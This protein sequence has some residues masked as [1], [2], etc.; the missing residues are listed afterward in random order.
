MDFQTVGRLLKAGATPDGAQVVRAKRAI[1]EELGSGSQTLGSLEKRVRESEGATLNF[2]ELQLADMSDEDLAKLLSRENSQVS[3]LRARVAMEVALERLVSAGIVIPL[4]SPTSIE[5][6]TTPDFAFQVTIGSRMSSRT[7]QVSISLDRPLLVATQYAL[8]PGV[9]GASAWNFD[10]DGFLDGLDPLHLD[11]RTRRCGVEAFTSY[12]RGSYLAAASMLGA[13]VEGAW[14]GAA[15]RRRSTLTALKTP[16]DRD[17][18]AQVQKHLCAHYRKSV[19]LNWRVDD[20]ERD[21]GLFREIRNYGVHPRGTVSADVE[22]HLQEDTCGL[23]IDAARRHL[24]TLAEV[25]SEA[26]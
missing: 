26:A 3:G 13:V 18:T 20:L 11:A 9:S 1:L 19:K 22:R 12:V 6:G 15:E 14:Y 16:L 5:G 21:A 8:A 2:G 7:Q 23:L 4:R 17:Q 10:V 25:D 24:V